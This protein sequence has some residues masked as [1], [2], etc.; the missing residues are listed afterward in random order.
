MNWKKLKADHGLAG[1]NILI[2]PEEGQPRYR[3]GVVKSI[4]D[5]H[6]CL[7]IND[8]FEYYLKISDG[9]LYVNIDEIK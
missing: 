9:W 4:D 1:A 3:N 2:R 5:I 6:V 7:I 8:M